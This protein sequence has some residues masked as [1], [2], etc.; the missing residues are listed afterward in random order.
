MNKF[1]LLLTLFVL[2]YSS[3]ASSGD[4]Q[5]KNY[6]LPN[7]GH[8]TIK[9]PILWEDNIKQPPNNLPPTI[10][11]NEKTGK[12]FQILITPIWPFN[13][14]TL[15][16]SLKKIYENVKKSS[17]QVLSEVIENEINIQEVQGKQGSG[18]YFKVTDKA[19]KPDEYKYMTQGIIKVRELTVSFTILTNDEQE[20]ISSNALAAIQG[21]THTNTKLDPG[22]A[23]TTDSHYK[24]KA[25]GSSWSIIFPKSDYKILQSKQRSNGRSR[26]FHLANNSGVNVSFFIEPSVKCASSNDCRTYQIKHPS[27]SMAASVNNREYELNNF[28]IIY[29]MLKEADKTSIKR[30]PQLAGKTINQMNINAHYVKNGYWADIHMSKMQSTPKDETTFNNFISSIQLLTE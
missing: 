16:A 20:T 25:D 5:L 18:Y 26:Y 10:N 13:K 11:F 8:I 7:H 21:I 12:K 9:V 24:L 19:P 6:I 22:T 2:I 30:I 4:Y 27:P 3:L 1:K 23:V 29:Y 17:N 15:S 28:S 14:N